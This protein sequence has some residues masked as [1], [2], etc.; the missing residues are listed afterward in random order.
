MSLTSASL[1]ERLQQSPDQEAWRRLVELYT[2]LIHGWLRRHANLQANDAD[3]LTQEVLASLVRRLPR[4]R[5]NQRP[6]A[7]RAWLR[8]VTVNCL[9]DF[10]RRR[11]GRPWAVAGGDPA[12]ML[13]ELEDSD[14]GLSQV[15][16]EEHDRHVAGALLERVRGEF[17]PSTWE[18]FRQLALEGRSAAEVGAALGLS[19]NAVLIAKSRVLRRLREEGRGL[20]G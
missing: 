9:R 17:T 16:D 5:H 14:S 20:I 18:A 1:L 8:T 3:D 13:A 10:W 12:R 4:F 15:W 19:P 2:P 6:G 7:F 11:R